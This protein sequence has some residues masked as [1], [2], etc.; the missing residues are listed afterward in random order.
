MNT[1]LQQP[2]REP[3]RAPT[4]VAPASGRALL[5]RFQRMLPFL[6]WLGVGVTILAPVLPY[7]YLVLPSPDS[8]PF[9]P[10]HNGL[11]VLDHTLSS[12]A[13][14]TPHTLLWMLLPPLFCH[15]FTYLLDTLLIAAGAAYYL[16]GRGLPNHAA[17]LGGGI[18][19]FAAYSFTLIAAG[20]RGFFYMGAYGIFLFG[21]LLR[22]VQTEKWRYYA[23]AGAC[24]GWV[25]DS[26]PDFSF[27]YL[28]VAA[29]YG[30]WLV[31]S[32]ASGVDRPLSRRLGAAVLRMPVFLLLLAL[33]SWSGVRDIFTIYRP[34]RENQMAAGTTAAEATV[35]GESDAVTRHKKW[36]FATNWSLP[37]EETVELVAPCI[38]GAQ[39]GDPSAPYWGRLGR[40]DGWEEHGQG[41]PNFRQH[42]VYLGAV[43]LVLALFAMAYAWRN[44][45][46]RSAVL[47]ANGGQPPAAWLADVPFWS[48]LLL[49][50]LL[51]AFGRYAPFYRLFYEIPYMSLLRAPVKFMRFAELSI[52][53]L[54]A[55]GLACLWQNARA[56][57]PARLRPWII[58]TALLSGLF[59]LAAI[60]V[61]L[62][63]EG[64]RSAI[65][66]NLPP[67]FTRN[68]ANRQELERILDLLRLNT[69]GSLLHAAVAFGVATLLLFGIARRW[70]T[71]LRTVVLLSAWV[72]LD[73]TLVDR[74]FIQVEDV[75]PFYE[76][77]EVVRRIADAMPEGA[78]LA[79]Y[80]PVRQPDWFRSSLGASRI[81]CCV[82]APGTA[83]DDP[84]VQFM[85]ALETDPFRFWEL[86]GAGFALVPASAARSLVGP[87][88]EFVQWVGFS[89]GQVITPT[90]QENALALLRV[91]HP[92]PY[93]WLSPSWDCV[94]NEAH[95]AAV[96]ARTGDP[97]QKAIVTG[98]CPPNGT[99]TAA[100][101]TGRVRVESIRFEHGARATRV[102]VA[103]DVPQILT[104]R[105]PYAEAADLCARVDGQ[106]VP[107][108]RSNH[109][110][111][112]VPVPAGS[113]HVALSSESRWI[114]PALSLSPLLLLGMWF[115][116]V[117]KRDA[118][119]A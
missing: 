16:R 104:V 71:P 25:V 10:D 94:S 51:L 64:M 84:Q 116:P 117:R 19:A 73:A 68:P 17:W 14:V 105:M 2:K 81:D 72:A 111:V 47:P 93:A 30:A 41:F 26:A 102:D 75:A 62:S 56:E 66:A 106:R 74:R 109:L 103:T 48:V 61:N 112:G 6:F 15:D 34:M 54:A 33:T 91:I 55:L 43:P 89:R 20:H 76:P 115:V 36:I 108:L 97:L 39:S 21:L 35:P 59:L 27:L 46:R 82:P 118:Q 11:R 85:R 88:A 40:T 70:L 13:C 101:Q 44:R 57:H 5:P 87:H 38:F 3:S 100:A 78:M 110:W 107:L 83:P 86:C 32:R 67:E 65:A 4:A 96:V 9:Y 92:V 113:H 24:A 80:A 42:A 37:P 45:R 119:A 69:A 31:L 22:A 12:G 99:T 8:S 114:W 90:S 60:V 49:V 7:Y 23:L 58:G 95:L 50:A 63:P 98:T 1:L 53:L 29:A 18:L 79:S 28:S 77:N 52:A